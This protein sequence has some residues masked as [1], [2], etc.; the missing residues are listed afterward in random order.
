MRRGRALRR[1]YGHAG[2]SE[3]VRV[4]RQKGRLYFV[5][6]DGEVR[7]TEMKRRGRRK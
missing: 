7:S 5:A 6:R 2:R 3:G 4:H 1:R